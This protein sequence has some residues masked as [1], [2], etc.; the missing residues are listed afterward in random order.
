MFCSS[1]H[2]LPLKPLTLRVD[3]E[4]LL[5]VLTSLPISHAILPHAVCFA[6]SR[7]VNHAICSYIDS[8]WYA[9]GP[10]RRCLFI[11]YIIHFDTHHFKDF[12]RVQSLSLPIWHSI[13]LTSFFK[14]CEIFSGNFMQ[15]ASFLR[16]SLTRRSHGYPLVEKYKMLLFRISPKKSSLFLPY[17]KRSATWNVFEEHIINLSIFIWRSW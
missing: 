15:W 8:S 11:Q 7:S 9:S 10:I 1:C 13:P 16:K 14:F 5:D 3:H 2:F 4:K 6:T 17:F 12:H